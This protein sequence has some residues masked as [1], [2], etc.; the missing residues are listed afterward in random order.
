MSYKHGLAAM[1][2]QMSDRVPHME[3]DAE[4]NWPLIKKVTG[5]DVT[6][7]AS[8]QERRKAQMAFCKAWNYDFKP[9]PFL[10]K[11]IFSKMMT[12]MGHCEYES[13][14]RDY[15]DEISCPFTDVEDVLNFDPWEVYGEIDTNKAK[16]DFTNHYNTLCKD[17]PTMI[18]TSGIY[19]TLITGLTYIFG[20]EMMLLACG[21]DAVR[22]GE[23]T[24]RY[25]SWI[26]QYYNALA[27][28][29]AEYIYSHD[30]LVWTS[31]AVFRPD[32]Y[33][34]YVFPNLKKF[35]DP[36]LE[37]GKKII[38]L[39]DGDYNEFVED[40]ADLG[41]HGFFFEPYVNLKHM[42]ETYGKT[43]IMIGNADTRVLLLGNKDD[44]YQEVK[45][46]IDLG[47]NCPGYFMSVSNG[48]P[49]NTPIDNALYYYEA[50][51]ELSRR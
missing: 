24:N 35:Y 41:V 16:A 29:D 36:I 38:Y 50:Y 49:Y 13:D 17:F 14:S 28:S 8:E 42:T 2:L 7:S 5:I 51:K 48:I 26:Q 30:D 15:D 20:W 34:K 21:T 40:I 47:K 10:G 37:S 11:D 22:F 18:N 19:V 39:G 9:T 31:G 23:L 25:A 4:M 46:C 1:N 3:T 6:P 32:W 27:E 12:N 43:H 33:R 45:R 44:I